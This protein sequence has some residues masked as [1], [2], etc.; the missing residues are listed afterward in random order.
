MLTRKMTL[1]I[2]GLND[3]DDACDDVDGD[4][5]NDCLPDILGPLSA[6]I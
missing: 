2:I 6:P 1:V 4:D 3:Y 5:D